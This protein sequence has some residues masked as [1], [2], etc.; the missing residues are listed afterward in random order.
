MYDEFR[1]EGRLLE[2]D[3]DVKVST[4]DLVLRIIRDY[5]DLILKQ[6]NKGYSGKELNLSRIKNFKYFV[7]DQCG[8]LKRNFPKNI[9]KIEDASNE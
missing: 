9:K 2:V 8:K 4:N 1:K 6:L 3:V 5:D 7:V